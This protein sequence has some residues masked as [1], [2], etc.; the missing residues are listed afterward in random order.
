MRAMK[1]LADF[2][3]ER[4]VLGMATFPGDDFAPDR[5]AEQIQVADEVEY[6]VPGRLVG[7]RRG[8]LMT[9]SSS[10]STKLDSLPPPARPASSSF[11]TSRRKP[12][13]RAGAMVSL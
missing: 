13:V 1:P 7:N 10:I 6:L 5:P 4:D 9:F 11:F 8:V 2:F 12:N 3:D